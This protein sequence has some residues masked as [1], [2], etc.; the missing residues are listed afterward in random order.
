MTPI[1]SCK[2]LP[3]MIN[4]KLLTAAIDNIRIELWW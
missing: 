1:K 3:T 4:Y 2:V